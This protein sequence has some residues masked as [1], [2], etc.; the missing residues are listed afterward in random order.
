MKV[1]DAIEI[2]ANMALLFFSISFASFIVLFIHKR[3]IAKFSFAKPYY[4]WYLKCF[5]GIVKYHKWYGLIAFV[6]MLLHGLLVYFNLQYLPTSGIAAGVGLFLTVIFGA[7]RAFIN[8]HPK[9]KMVHFVLAIM[10]CFAVTV[11]YI[12]F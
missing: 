1:Y 12:Q 5:K 9:L 7:I 8:K 10:T 2:F 3:F 6:S 4:Q 11:H